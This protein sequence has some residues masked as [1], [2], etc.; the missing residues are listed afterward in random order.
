V[1][2]KG[3]DAGG[4]QEAC[5]RWSSGTLN[6]VDWCAENGNP[7]PT[8][9]QEAGSA[10]VISALDRIKMLHQTKESF[11]IPEGFNLDEFTGPSFGVFQGPLTKVKIWFSPDVAGYLKEKIW[12]EG[13]KIHKEEDGSVLFEA[14][15]LLSGYRG[16]LEPQE[17]I[18]S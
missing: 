15:T 12:H 6:I 14:E 16:D 1:R 4:T 9:N 3:N 2:I 11:D 7:S 13:Q 10:F 18:V 5:I 17:M 8:W